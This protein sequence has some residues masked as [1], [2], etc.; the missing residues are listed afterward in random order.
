MKL[1]FELRGP[2]FAMS[3][4]IRRVAG[5]I[6]HSYTA[7]M[8]NDDRVLGATTQDGL[9]AQAEQAGELLPRLTVAYHPDPERIGE[10]VLLIGLIGGQAT[11]LSRVEPPFYDR[12]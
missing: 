6:G 7:P 2:G 4:W 12:R 10:E 9:P 3:P 11:G 8:A 1:A 5:A